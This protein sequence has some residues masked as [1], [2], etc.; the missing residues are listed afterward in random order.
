MQLRD[1]LVQFIDVGVKRPVLGID[2]LWFGKCYMLNE[3]WPSATSGVSSANNL[4][5]YL[6]D[7]VI[8]NLTSKVR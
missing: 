3:F 8:A 4:R 2:F 5:E 7:E 1:F 6:L